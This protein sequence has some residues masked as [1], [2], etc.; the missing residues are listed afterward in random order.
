MPRYNH[1]KTIENN[2]GI[3][4]AI[5]NSLELK[6]NKKELFDYLFRVLV[7]D[8][9]TQSPEYE[10]IIEKYPSI[11]DEELAQGIGKIIDLLKLNVN[12]PC[13]GNG[14]DLMYHAMKYGSV[15]DVKMLIEKGYNKDNTID[16]QS[17][18]FLFKNTPNIK[19]YE[20]KKKVLEENGYLSYQL[21]DKSIDYEEIDRQKPK[22]NEYIVISMDDY[23]KYKDVLEQ[24]PEFLRDMVKQSAYVEPTRLMVKLRVY[25]VLKSDIDRT[26]MLVKDTNGKYE[27][28]KRV[29][30]YREVEDT[31]DER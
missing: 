24:T 12:T 29:T 11:T 17:I 7:H 31:R 5:Q 16:N 13:Y 3:M 15:E 1:E 20:E 4:R 21:K 18:M 27:S 19:D 23:K 28:I 30:R 25:K 10:K 14:Q 22:N 2:R 6:I 26:S 8:E 9:Y